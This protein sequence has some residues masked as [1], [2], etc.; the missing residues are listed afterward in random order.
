MNSEG[1]TYPELAFNACCS[2][3]P[4]AYEVIGA[5]YKFWSEANGVPMV[6]VLYFVVCPVCKSRQTARIVSDNERSAA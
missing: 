5:G 6:P 1:M 3:D 4:A 2:P